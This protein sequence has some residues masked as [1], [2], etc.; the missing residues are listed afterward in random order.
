MTPTSIT[1]RLL[2]AAAAIAVIALHGTAMA[3][4]LVIADSP[5]FLTASAEPLV[6]LALSNDEQLYHKAY[7]DFDD[8]DGDGLLDIGYKDTI[9]YYGYFDSKKCYGYTGTSDSGN[10]FPSAN[11]TGP[12]S[13]HCDTVTAGRWSGNFL[14]WAS[15][16]RMDALRKVLYG[17][18]RSTDTSTATMLERVY[19]PSDNHAWTKLYAATD[20]EKYTPYSIATYPS[21]ITMCNV[22]PKGTGDDR[23]ET[24]TT[25]PRFRVAKGAWTEWAAQEQRQCLWTSEFTPADAGASPSDAATADKL[26][27]YTVRVKVCDST[28]PGA[29]NCKAYGTSLKP[30]GLLQDFADADKLKMRFGLMT[31]SY[32]KRKSGGVLRKNIS[33]MTDE[34]SATDGTFVAGVDGIVRSINLMRISRYEYSAPGYGSGSGDNCPF[35]QNTWN[36]GACSNWGNPMGEMYLEA[37][38][39]FVGGQTANFSS[40]DDKWIKNLK[41]ASWVNPYGTSGESLPG[42][43]APYCAKPSIIAVSTGVVSFDNDEFGGASD[44]S[45]LNV[46]TETDQVGADEGVN[47]GL[48]YVGSL[49]GGSP[50]DVCT[51]KTV[52]A[53]STVTGIC[54][55]SASL[56]GSFK[57]AGLA[58]F[59][60]KKDTKLQMVGTKSIKPVDTFAV[61]LAA[62]IPAIKVKIGTSVVTIIPTGY[63]VRNSNAMQLVNFRVISQ[64]TDGSQGTFFMNYENAPS[65]SDYDNDMKG[66]LSYVVSGTNI[67]IIMYQTGSSAGATQKM[68]YIIDGVTDAGTHYLLSNN[69]LVANVQQGGST[70]S[71]L[72]QAA[73]NTKCKAGN[74][75]LDP[76]DVSNELCF[77]AQTG[78][79]TPA[80]NTARAYMR[81]VKTHTVGAAAT[82]TLKSP[83]WYAA[84]WG[85][86]NDKNKDGVMQP[87][88]WDGNGDGVPDAYFPV[89]NAGTLG[90]ELTKAFNEIIDRNSSASSAS[91]NSGS[92]STLSRV[93]Q[94]KFNSTNW[95]GELLAYGIDPNTGALNASP[96]WDAGPTSGPKAA[97]LPAAGLRNIITINSDDTKVPFRWADIDATRKLQLDDATVAPGDATLQ[98][99]RLNYLRGDAANEGTTPGKFRARPS[100]LGDIVSS[101]PIFVGEP[102]FNY[103]DSLET[104]AYSTFRTNNSGTKARQAVLYTGANDGMLHAFN[105]DDGSEMMAFIPSAV[106]AN[107]KE[108]SRQNYVHRFYVDGPPNM[109]DVFYDDDW[110]TVLT[111]GLNKGGKG[112]YALDITDPEK[113]SDETKASDVILWEFTDTKA[114]PKGDVDLGYTYSQPAIVRLHNTTGTHWAAVFGNGYNNTGSG[115]AVLY[116]VDIKTGEAIAKIDTKVGSTGTPN[117]LSTPAVVDING[118]S[119]ADYV[120]AGDLRGNMW[121]FDI[122][123]PSPA[124]WKVAYSDASGPA[125]LFTAMDAGTH[126]QP[127]TDRPEV[128]RGPNGAGMIVLF[129]TG[130]FLEATDK[131]VTVTPVGSQRVQS[132]YGIVDSN[133]GV[134]ATD[135]VTGR[136]QLGP[137]KIDFEG[138]QTFGSQSVNVRVPSD[139][140]AGAKGWYMDLVQPAWYDSSS[141]GYQ[142]ERVVANPILRNGRIIFATLIPSTD[143]C[144]PGGTS[145][146]MELDALSGGR[147]TTTPFDL[148]RDGKFDENDLVEITLPD[149]TK[150]KVPAGGIGSTV[151][152]TPEPGI[153]ASPTAEYKYSPGTTGE[154]SVTIENPGVNSYGRQS[155]RQTR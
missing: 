50:N 140:A 105:A 87:A 122:R 88:E 8:V 124:N 120:F 107:L 27:E 123:D 149:G 129:G 133:S 31:G 134:A 109:G 33:R 75:A 12:N 28:L 80:P 77:F 54:P 135:I 21:G 67:K 138:T 127:I 155:W 30:V 7:T 23:S 34:V 1:T 52:T 85:G 43:K 94:A 82:S 152:I 49:T 2:G 16:T 154:I 143:L 95:T 51:S 73:I 108:L 118:D 137:Q 102:Q 151:G 4:P 17:G 84:K 14:N 55:E 11:A 39:Y 136:S 72:T 37:L 98:E 150:T 112:I 128:G 68:G 153:L 86:Y 142:G 29:E 148:N 6:M 40:D 71:T 83:L 18:Y 141:T 100:K 26:D 46:N 125:P 44:I 74:F 69:D 126:A 19:V 60:H 70:F 66:I 76:A 63:N 139:N 131:T 56:Q 32:G 103:S 78:S 53:L 20:L 106:F 58:E 45:G 92:I 62:P 59:A 81:G 15:M 24:N 144:E 65:G 113:F 119:I 90:D 47:G 99:N 110:H 9:A 97:P 25:S 41:E 101:S 111:G 35:N 57:I 36:N 42:G 64:S 146:L 104:K 93:Y 89:T 61:A 5:L 132:F 130:K 116:I 121:K 147:L 91:V 96:E 79:A 117:G 145:W 3:A 38:R 22:T 13:H 48:W 10:F 114:Y 115:H